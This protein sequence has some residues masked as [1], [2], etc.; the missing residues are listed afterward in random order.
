MQGE[1]IRG[2][3]SRTCNKRAASISIEGAFRIKAETGRNGNDTEYW[4]RAMVLAKGR[5]GEKLKANIKQHIRKSIAH[6]RR[7]RSHEEQNRHDSTTSGTE[8]KLD[9]R[10]EHNSHR[11]TEGNI[12]NYTSNIRTQQYRKS[13]RLFQQYLLHGQVFFG[14]LLS[15]YLQTV[16]IINT[17]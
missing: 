2:L 3:C 8:S 6:P 17:N 7:Q 12:Y 15:F 14:A 5:R 13:R 9:Q 10:F 16:K 1:E 4:N 11:E